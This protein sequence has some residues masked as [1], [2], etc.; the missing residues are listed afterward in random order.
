MRVNDLEVGE[1]GG[2]GMQIYVRFCL[3]NEESAHSYCPKRSDEKQQIKFAKH[4]NQTIRKYREALQL[5]R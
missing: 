2:R 5:N 4:I 3:C 1:E